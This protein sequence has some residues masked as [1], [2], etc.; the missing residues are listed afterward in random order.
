MSL[1]EYADI[2]L[3]A[4][5]DPEALAKLT[6]EMTRASP[7][8]LAFRAAVKLGPR[9]P[10]VTGAVA[11]ARYV[12]AFARSALETGGASP[13]AALAE[14]CRKA[15]EAASLPFRREIEGIGKTIDVRTYLRR[16]DVAGPDAHA[17]LLR[18][19]LAGDLCALDVD[20]AITQSGA[21]KAAEFAA[22]LAGDGVTAPPHRAVRVELYGL[23]DAGRF[24]PL[25]VGRTPGGAGAD[26]LARVEHADATAPTC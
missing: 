26:A 17:A 4:D 3:A 24:S 13:E 25:E 5:L 10:A 11:G 6:A 21:A 2:R 19:G 20:C 18:A 23:D 7:A 1:D 9:D 14:R 12:L 16:A 15:M 22:V 8:G